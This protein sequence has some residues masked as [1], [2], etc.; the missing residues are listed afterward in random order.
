MKKIRMLLSDINKGSMNS[1]L[2]DTSK[3][4]MNSML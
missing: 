3:E 4:F 2:T 1:I